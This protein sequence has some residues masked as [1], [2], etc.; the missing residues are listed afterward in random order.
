M[1]TEEDLLAIKPAEGVF[2]VGKLVEELSRNSVCAF[3][4]QNDGYSRKHDL[5]VKQQRLILDVVHRPYSRRI[6]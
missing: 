2:K 5:E 1:V 6:T 4:E 3:P